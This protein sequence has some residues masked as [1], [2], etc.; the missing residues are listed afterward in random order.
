MENVVDLTGKKLTIADFEYTS[1]RKDNTVGRFIVDVNTSKLYAIPANIDHPEF[2][3]LLT[4]KSVSELKSDPEEFSNFISISIG[5]ENTFISFILIGL[6]GFEQVMKDA[7]RKRTH[8][9]FL[10]RLLA[11]DKVAYHSKEQLN[12]AADLGRFFIY[13]C[14]IPLAKNYVEQ[15]VWEI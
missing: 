4:G 12:R 2:V 10:G 15:V 9:K 13:D 6:A 5:I 8:P 1:K 3:G 14:E 11:H 7:I